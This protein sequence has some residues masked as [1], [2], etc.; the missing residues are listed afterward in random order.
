MYEIIVLG[1]YFIRY[2]FYSIIFPYIFKM[3]FIFTELLDI[4][5]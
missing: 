3:Y 1:N 4:K 5:W 2:N